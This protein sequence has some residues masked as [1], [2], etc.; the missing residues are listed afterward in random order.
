MYLTCSIFNSIIQGSTEELLSYLIVR[1][2]NLD[3]E[4]CEIMMLFKNEN[5]ISSDLAPEHIKKLNDYHDSFVRRYINPKITADRND[6]MR[7]IMQAKRIS[8]AGRF[9]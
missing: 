7:V 2:K 1:D 4:N 3:P 8:T 5:F 9:N 6:S